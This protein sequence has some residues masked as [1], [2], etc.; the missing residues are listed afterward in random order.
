MGSSD[1][2]FYV[3]LRQSACTRIALVASSDSGFSPQERGASL[4]RMLFEHLDA[5]TWRHFLARANELNQTQQPST[6]P[7]ERPKGRSR[8]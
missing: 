4:A 8:F 7:D 5:T 6:P 2:I 1:V 3:R